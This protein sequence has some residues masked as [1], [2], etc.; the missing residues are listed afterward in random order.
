[1]T[2]DERLDELSAAHHSEGGHGFSYYVLD[3]L[4]ELQHRRIDKLERLLCDW[5]AALDDWRE[6]VGPASCQCASCVAPENEATAIH[7]RLKARDA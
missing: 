7:L 1:M 3:E 2:D 5:K 6:Y 4:C